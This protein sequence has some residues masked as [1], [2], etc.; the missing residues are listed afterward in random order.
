[1]VKKKWC[2]PCKM[3]EPTINDVAIENSLDFKTIKAE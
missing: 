3:Y 1:M 2:N